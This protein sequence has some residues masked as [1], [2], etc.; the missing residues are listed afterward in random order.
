[1][2]DTT[3]SDIVRVLEEH[4]EVIGSLYAAFADCLPQMGDFWRKLAAQEKAH[5]D[6]LRSLRKRLEFHGVMLNTRKFNRQAV[7]TSLGFIRQLL[8]RI[9][10]EP[11]TPVRALSLAAD[12]E[13]A[14]IEKDFFA[15]FESDA[16]EMKRDFQ[17]LRNH[18]ARH[19]KLIL[20][21]LEAEKRGTSP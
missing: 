19:R 4:E 14:M 7:Q 18:T 5:A 15:V 11:M 6:V 3:N 10:R 2:I 16:A 9:P 20:E 17:A 1:M 13:Q 8:E 12:Y 21:R